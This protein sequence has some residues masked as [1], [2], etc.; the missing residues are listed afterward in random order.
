MSLNVEERSM[1]CANAENKV[2]NN[3]Y[4][5]YMVNKFL[6]KL[7]LFISSKRCQ[8]FYALNEAEYT[9]MILRFGKSLFC[10]NWRANFEDW[11]SVAQMGTSDVTFRLDKHQDKFKAYCYDCTKINSY[12]A[13]ALY[14]VKMTKT[15][16][17]NIISYQEIKND[18]WNE[19][20]H[21]NTFFR[22]KNIQH[23]NSYQKIKLF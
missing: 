17:V 5:K 20:I 13:L 16:R 2:L 11:F 8:F 22:L 18:E 21:C 23:V 19:K 14:N 7:Y 10:R 6:E 1:E 4:I 15:T 3:C 12:W 9:K